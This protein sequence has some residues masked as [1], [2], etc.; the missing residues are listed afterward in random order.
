MTRIALLRHGV[1]EW[2]AIKRIQG[3]TDTHLAEAGRAALARL[4]LPA[5]LD[6]YTA[7]SSP[8]TRCLETAAILGV[9]A[10]RTDPRLA[11]MAWGDYEGLTLDEIRARDGAAFAAK[12]ARGLDFQPPGGESPRM[13]QARVGFFLAERAAEGAPAM[14]F[15]H[16]GVIRAVLALATGWPMIGKPPWKLAW[17]AAQ[18]VT[19][20]PAGRPTVE[21]INLPL[22]ERA[23]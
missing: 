9:A 21:T 7:W 11:E 19:L 15:T 13:V 18:V 16:R 6:G 2:N 8:L 4:R 20:D 12:E 14:V 22:A 17:N 5:P 10:P 3:R 23:P 1:T